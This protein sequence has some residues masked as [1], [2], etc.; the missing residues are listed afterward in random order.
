MRQPRRPSSR[1]ILA[2]S[3]ILMLALHLGGAGKALGKESMMATL[4]AP[5]AFATPPGTEILVGMTVTALADTGIVDVVGSPIVLILTGRHGATTEAFGATPD[6]ARPGH[7]EMRITIPE[8]G[9]RAADVVIRGSS[10][11]QQVDLPIRLMEDPFTFGGV[12]ARTA[13]VAPAPTPMLTPFPRATAVAPVAPA[14]AGSPATGPAGGT[15]NPAAAATPAATP[16]ETGTRW[17]PALALVALGIA[18]VV[19]VRL[20]VG[21]PAREGSDAA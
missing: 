19:A 16:P 17:P 4:D 11:G 9:V 2:L 3:L 12:T 15:A 10:G 8:G 18:V 5:I 20:R 14:P 13:Q 7:Y 1:P 21:R 6:R